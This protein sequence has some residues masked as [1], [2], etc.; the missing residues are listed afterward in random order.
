VFAIAFMNSAKNGVSGGTNTAVQLG[1][2]LNKPTHVF[3]LNS[4]KW[5]KYNPESKVFEEESTPVLTKSFAGIGTRDIQNYNIYKDGKWVTREQ[6]VG[7]DKAKVALKAI[8]DVFN[9]T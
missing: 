5:Y 8:E 2:S 7:D 1:I 4:E 6:Y 9:K 3:D